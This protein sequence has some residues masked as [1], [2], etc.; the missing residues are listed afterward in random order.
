MFSNAPPI[1]SAAK[2][3]PAANPANAPPHLLPAEGAAA[4]GAV[5]GDCLGLFGA[6]CC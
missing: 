1:N 5:A 6:A 4:P 3:P 2:R